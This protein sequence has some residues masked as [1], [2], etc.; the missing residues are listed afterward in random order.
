MGKMAYVAVA[1]VLVLAIVGVLYLP[2]AVA[3]SGLV[4]GLWWG[5]T[6]FVYGPSDSGTSVTVSLD[7][8]AVCSTTANVSNQWGCNFTAPSSAGEYNVTINN[9]TLESQNISVSPSYGTR[10]IGTTPR[11]SLSVPV[12]VQEPSG[13]VSQLVTRFIVSMGRA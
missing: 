4:G 2:D 7:G 12:V 5:Q 6:V 13:Q 9:G 1:P 3:A 10:P 8:S 11:T